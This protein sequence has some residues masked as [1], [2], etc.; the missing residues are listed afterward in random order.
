MHDFVFRFRK[1]ILVLACLLTLPALLFAGRLR[2]DLDFF[3]LL[4]RDD[5]SVSSYFEIAREVWTHAPLIVL[6]KVGPGVKPPEAQDL[7]EGLAQGFCQ[8][9]GVRSVDYRA[10]QG[11][12]DQ[13]IHLFLE[14]LTA[15]LNPEEL[16][17]LGRR[18]SDEAIVRQVAENRRILSTPFG[19]AA[20]A[21]ILQDPLGLMRGILPRLTGGG[22]LN[23][24]EVP[25][26]F[27][28]ASDRTY[29]IFVRCEK[30]PQDVAFSKAL[31][32][33]VQRVK[34]EAMAAWQKG[35]AGKISKAALITFAGGYPIAV[36]DEAQSKHDI[37]MTIITSLVGVLVLFGLTFRRPAV[38]LCGGLTLLIGLIWTLG[39]A[40]LAF[41]SLNVISF[42]FSCVLI[43]LG[44]DFAIHVANRFYEEGTQEEGGVHAALERVYREAGGG[45]LVGGITTALAF[46]AV[47]IS[48]FG[49]FRQ[50]GLLTGTG[51]L[52]CMLAMLLVLPVLL[53]LVSKRNGKP[54]ALA[55]FGLEILLGAVGHRPGMVLFAGLGCLVFL[56]IFGTKV[57]FDDNLRHFRPPAD[58]V[59]LRQD[60]VKAWLGGS[61]GKVLLV[62][63]GRSEAEVLSVGARIRRALETARREGLLARVDSINRFF[64]APEIQ[65]KNLLYLQSH[66]EIFDPVRIR[67]AFT[68]ALRE[69]GFRDEG[70][71]DPYL[72]AL[73]RG[74]TP[75]GVIL[76]SSLKKTSAGPFIDRFLYEKGGSFRLVCYLTPSRDLW[77]LDQTKRFREGI[78]G[79]LE[80]HGIGPK[81]YHLTGAGLLTADLKALLLRS[82]RSSLWLAFLSITLVL[83]LYYR[84]LKLLCLSAV[85]LAAGLVAAAG[86]MVLAGVDFNFFNLVVIPMI[87]GIGIDDG[88]HLANTYRFH[89][90]P[91]ATVA[92]A[93]TG[94]AVV[95][96]SL[97]TL[98]GFGSISLSHYPGLRSMGYV[99]LIG[100]SACLL[101]SLLLLPALFGL[102]KGREKG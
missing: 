8:V 54:G 22:P 64:Q 98:V 47:G 40:A 39:F 36:R 16:A 37:K 41:G 69:Q 7:V 19:T 57:R 68:R 86:I 25:G 60:R 10:H 44:V 6:V 46:Y 87:V 52:F 93:L 17:D 94:R 49:G 18:L 35:R 59:F 63:E 14:R 95:L 1:S 85:P 56:G 12:M 58:E 51:I 78:V 48:D 33:R 28:S 45:I 55:G 83:F 50:L 4:P 100:I 2:L 91:G 5:P 101:S 26:F 72:D 24:T 71:Y 77:T 9:P 82:L 75:H 53:V 74:L 62:A 30:P 27:Y 76:P 21:L 96:T 20:E 34:Q 90:G 31:M 15:F 97:T 81:D 88:V 38:L 42:T 92:L 89:K 102:L 80:S 65:A 13:W 79:R 61:T 67:A 66:R 23:A 43:G 3:S 84:S 73:A 70:L 29:F 11:V 32:G 99:A